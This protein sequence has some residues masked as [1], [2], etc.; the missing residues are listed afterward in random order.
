M[1]GIVGYVGNQ[2]AVPILIG[3]LAKLE[4]RGY[5]SAGVA[6]LQGQKITVRRSVGKLVNLQKSLQEKE[7]Q[8]HG[9]H[10]SHPMGD[11][12]QA[13]R[14]ECPSASIEGLCARAQRHHRELSAA[15]AAV[16]KRGLQ[17]SVGDRH[18]SA[19][20]SDR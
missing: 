1:C 7:L 3:G 17:V 8:R 5:D 6:I 9:G 19:G 2:E 4:Y 18:G 13:V 20:P 11:A 14:A 12:W 10:R 15:E 16:G